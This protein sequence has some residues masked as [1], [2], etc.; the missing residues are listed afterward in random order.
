[1]IHSTPIFKSQYH[2]ATFEDATNLPGSRRDPAEIS[3]VINAN[4]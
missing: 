2:H 3:G 1:V 4:L